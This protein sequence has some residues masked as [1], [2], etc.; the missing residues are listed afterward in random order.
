MMNEAIIKQIFLV[1]GLEK[2]KSIEKIKIGFTNK[3][4]SINDKFIL[5][6]CENLGN[7]E[8]FEREVFFY[9]FFRD[10]LPVPKIIVYDSSKNVYDKFF[11][12][13]RKIQGDNLYS[14]WH[15]MGDSERKNIVKQLCAILKTINNS[16]YESFAKKFKLTAQFNWH[17]KIIGK[18]QNSLRQISKKK[19]ISSRL[20]AAINNFVEINHS[21]LT[22]QKIALVY[23]DAH[24]DNILVKRNK[25]VGILDFERVDLSSVDYV[26]DIIKRMVDYPKKY[27]CEEFE[28]F[29]KKK[30]YSQLLSWFHEFY[31]ELFVFKNLNVRL[32]LY[33]VEHDLAALLRL[34]NSSE[35]KRMIAKT[36]KYSRHFFLK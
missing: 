28:K 10:K 35:V 5:K 11:I 1:N 20:V 33:A 30:D 3:V 16:S 19:I 21:V 2:V 17:D 23:W 9:H 29:A 13:Y 7:G 27:V 22:E 15:L 8:N 34:P 18:I 6:V 32:D 36:I 31:P 12:V 4:Y 14:K 25:I 26:L 24:F